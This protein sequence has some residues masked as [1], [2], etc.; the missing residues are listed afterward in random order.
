MKFNLDVRV[1]DE[2][3]INASDREYRVLILPRNSGREY[4]RKLINEELKELGKNC[5]N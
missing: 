2:K 4:F 1:L 5:K 3:Y